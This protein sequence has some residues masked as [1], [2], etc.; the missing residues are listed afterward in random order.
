MA[1]GWGFSSG[2]YRG[3]LTSDRAENLFPEFM[4]GHRTASAESK[5]TMVGA[6]G[7]SLFATLP[8]SPG[9]GIV[10]A[11]GQ[12]F[13][14]GGGVFYTIEDDGTVSDPRAIEDGPE[15]VQIIPTTNDFLIYDG[16]GNVWW[17]HGGLMTKVLTDVQA[18]AIADSYGMALRTNTGDFAFGKQINI[19]S[20]LVYDSWDPLDFQIKQTST[21]TLINIFVHHAFVYLFG[22]RTIE[23]WINTGAEFP[24]ER[25]PEGFMDQGLW[26]KYSVAK[27]DESL[28]WLGG[29]DRGVGQVWRLDG[30]TP[31]AISDRALERELKDLAVAGT[32]TSDAIGMPY[33][34]S[35]HSFYVLHFPTANITRAYDNTTNMWHDRG[36]WD[37]AALNQDFGRFHAHAYGKHFVQDYRNG[38]IYEASEDIFQNDGEAIRFLR[39][40]PIVSNDQKWVRHNSLWLDKLI[41]TTAETIYMRFSD[42]GGKTWSDTR[43]ITVQQVAGVADPRAMFRQL[44]RSRNRVYEMWTFGNVRQRWTDAYLELAAGNGT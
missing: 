11:H 31:K 39:R 41:G 4:D 26:A 20:P 28:F 16:N 22:K 35:G 24:F 34:E 5:F 17:R 10:G 2:S 36:S 37:G 18:L 42:D 19:S 7:K 9:R 29:D 25:Y 14:V 30:Q 43:E 32:D 8:T 38:K 15:P 44:G 6:P 1:G 27:L 3:S 40:F 23:A 33:Q 13:G 21:D 12:L